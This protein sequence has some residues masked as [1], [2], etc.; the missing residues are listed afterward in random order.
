M[1]LN[2]NRASN[3]LYHENYD[4]IGVM[5]ASLINYYPY[6]E[7][8]SEELEIKSLEILN[9]VI[10]DFDD[11]VS[12]L[13]KFFKFNVRE[14]DANFSFLLQLFERKFKTIEKIKVAGST[15]MAACGLHPGQR[16]AETLSGLSSAQILLTLTEFAA[17]VMR[18]L[19]NINREFETDFKL[20]VGN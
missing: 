1:Y 15:Y 12:C 5:F 4:C 2:T 19:Q 16:N 11:T 13:L 6:H 9:K 20:R 7:K 3:D 17:S 10:C 14:K 8:D 18:K